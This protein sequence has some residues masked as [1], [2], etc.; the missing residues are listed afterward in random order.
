M[1]E[2]LEAIRTLW[3][4]I[5]ALVGVVVWA[6]TAVLNGKRNTDDM[7]TLVGK[8]DGIADNVGTISSD[9]KQTSYEMSRVHEDMASV[10]RELEK[11][12]KIEVRLSTLEV[13]SNILMAD[14]I[15]DD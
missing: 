4:L 9:V 12:P 14:K 15:K 3:P 11:I 6:V 1:S 13:R 2:I 8:I 10:K 7:K 5:T